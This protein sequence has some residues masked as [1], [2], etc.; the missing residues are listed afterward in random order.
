MLGLGDELPT[1]KESFQHHNKALSTVFERMNSE[2]RKDLDAVAKEW[3]NQGYPEE[4]RR[5][6]ATRSLSCRGRPI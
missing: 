2:Q 6:Q 4:H 3:G 1:S 5:R